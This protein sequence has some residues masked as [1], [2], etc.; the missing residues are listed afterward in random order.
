MFTPLFKLLFW[1]LSDTFSFG[2]S[3]NPP[4]DK[5]DSVLVELLHV[6]TEK[7]PLLA[8]KLGGVVLLYLFLRED[9]SLSGSSNSGL[10]GMSLGSIY[11]NDLLTIDS[12]V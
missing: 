10:N 8:L 11:T 4:R 5:D 9:C 2:P 6:A 12:L 7:G 1:A 3:T